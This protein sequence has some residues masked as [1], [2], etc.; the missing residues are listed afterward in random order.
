MQLQVCNWRIVV[1]GC[2]CALL[3]GG[4]CDQLAPRRNEVKHLHVLKSGRTVYHLCIFVSFLCYV[5][6]YMRIYSQHAQC[7]RSD[8]RVRGQASV[9][10]TAGAVAG[11]GGVDDELDGL[12][13]PSRD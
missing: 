7:C 12:K 8:A 11:T 9:V 3:V 1:R 6:F 13:M 2:R 4:S 10:R 5:S